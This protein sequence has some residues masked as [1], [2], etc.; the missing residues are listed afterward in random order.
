MTF[1]MARTAALLAALLLVPVAPAAAA[2]K[3]D[4]P[5]TPFPEGKPT[6]RAV[7]F[8]RELNAVRPPGPGR[9]AQRSRAITP[10]QLAKGT[11]LPG[12]GTTPASE[13]ALPKAASPS[14]RA[15]VNGGDDSPAAAA[16]P[17]AL[18]ALLLAVAA[19]GFELRARRR[20]AR[21]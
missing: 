16:I 5:Y 14:G 6:K 8:V 10:Q 11:K 20:P 4:G 2:R 19:I 12:P 18:V 1:R 21:V 17:F 3:D 15:G 9:A 7:N 13:R